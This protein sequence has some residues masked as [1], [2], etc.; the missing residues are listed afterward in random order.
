MLEE[1]KVD[2][3]ALC[4]FTLLTVVC[5]GIVIVRACQCLFIFFHPFTL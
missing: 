5:S 4:H 1:T 2:T 3:D